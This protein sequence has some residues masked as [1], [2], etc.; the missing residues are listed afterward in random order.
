MVQRYYFLSVLQQAVTF[1]ETGTCRPRQEGWAKVKL[2]N[3]TGAVS[4]S[5]FSKF[6]L[7]V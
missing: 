7:T 1:S 4:F 3:F 5:C 2:Y 6:G